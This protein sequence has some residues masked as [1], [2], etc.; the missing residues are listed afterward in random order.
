[1]IFRAI[2]SL[3]WLAPE[4]HQQG[5]AKGPELLHSFDQ[6]PTQ[7]YFVVSG[8]A[9]GVGKQLRSF[10]ALS[11]AQNFSGYR[12]RGQG[13]IES[14]DDCFSTSVHDASEQRPGRSRCEQ[15]LQH[16]WYHWPSS[17]YP[18]QLGPRK[19]AMHVQGELITT[20]LGVQYL[21][22]AVHGLCMGYRACQAW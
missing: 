2:K 8:P 22:Q 10:G 11:G 7:Q 19:Q 4:H 3:A 16:Q 12:A 9:S 6:T 5:T 15:A 21:R 17:T 13:L 18:H 1:V 20:I 14:C